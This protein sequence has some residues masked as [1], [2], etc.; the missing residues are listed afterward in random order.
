MTAV[1]LT[2]EGRSATE[3]LTWSRRMVESVIRPAAGGL[4]PS[5]R[6]IAGYHFGW[7]DEHG[8]PVEADGAGRRDHGEPRRAGHAVGGQRV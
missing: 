2:A 4:P 7:W 5:M 1:E 3:V 6:H 8:G